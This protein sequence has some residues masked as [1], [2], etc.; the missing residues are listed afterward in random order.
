MEVIGEVVPAAVPPP[1]A[2]ESARDAAVAVLVHHD[3]SR[4]VDVD[5]PEERLE[6][7]ADIGIRNGLLV[8]LVRDEPLAMA[9]AQDLAARAELRNPALVGRAVD[10]AGL[11]GL[12]DGGEA[13]SDRLGRR[14]VALDL[15]D[16]A[17]LR[18]HLRERAVRQGR[19]VDD[20]VVVG[21]P[22]AVA[23]ADDDGGALDQALGQIVHEVRRLVDDETQNARGLPAA[24]HLGERLLEAV[25]CVLP[26][27]QSDVT[28]HG[29]PFL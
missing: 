15:D 16:A 2:V 27:V 9:E 25:L 22:E 13:Q 4:E 18:L 23:V 3:R 17:V 6:S 19:D 1:A 24:L 12:Q 7:G 8:V 11:R 14:G 29:A 26:E 28:G 21:H 5:L 10:P 20:E